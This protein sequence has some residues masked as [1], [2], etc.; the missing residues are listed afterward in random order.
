[1]A[2]TG[3]APMVLGSSGGAPATSGSGIFPSAG[4]VGAYRIYYAGAKEAFDKRYAYREMRAGVAVPPDLSFHVTEDTVDLGV[5]PHGLG[6]APIANKTGSSAPFA[7][8]GPVLTSSSAP[9]AYGP[10]GTGISPFDPLT[11]SGLPAFF[12][13]FTIDHVRNENRRGP[14]RAKRPEIFPQVRSRARRRETHRRIQC[15]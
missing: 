14:R 8:T 9:A 15:V 12:A 10:Y 13:P 5:A 4:Y 3:Y 7:P 1:M 11:S 6:Y 2:Q